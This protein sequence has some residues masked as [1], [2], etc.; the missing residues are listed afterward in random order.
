MPFTV[1]SITTT[2]PARSL[3]IRAGPPYVSDLLWGVRRPRGRPRAER[4]V[5]GFLD[6]RQVDDVGDPGHGPLDN[7][8][9]ADAALDHL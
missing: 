6:S 7:R 1:T 5:W 3:H 8:M 4:T 9:V 2:C